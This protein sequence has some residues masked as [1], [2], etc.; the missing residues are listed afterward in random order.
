MSIL[1]EAEKLRLKAEDL[2]KKKK[3]MSMYEAY[4]IAAKEI[5]KGD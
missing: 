1:E 5:N 4:L 2:R 3:D